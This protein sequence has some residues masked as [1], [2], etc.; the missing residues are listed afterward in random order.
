MTPWVA[1]MPSATSATRGGSPSEPASLRFSWPRKAVA[2]AYG[3]A[4]MHASK[5]SVAAA[6]QSPP[7]PSDAIASTRPTAAWSLRSWKWRARRYSSVWLK[8][9]ACISAS[10]SRGGRSRSIAAS[11][12]RSSARQSSGPMSAASAPLRA[13]PSAMTRSSIR[14]TTAG[15]GGAPSLRP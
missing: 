14:S 15:S 11:H 5:T 3:T 2:G 12:A 9:S 7:A 13:S 6:P 10:S 1:P 8:S 4:G